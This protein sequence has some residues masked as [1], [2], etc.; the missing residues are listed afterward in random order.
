MN[1][2]SMQRHRQPSSVFRDLMAMDV[3][4]E[5]ARLAARQAT[6]TNAQLRDLQAR[7]LGPQGVFATFSRQVARQGRQAS[8][9]NDLIEVTGQKHVKQIEKALAFALGQ[10]R[11]RPACPNPF[12]GRSR[13]WLCCIVFDT[14]APCTVLE[15]YTAAEALR[16]H[17][18]DYF[19]LLIAT[20]RN[21]VERRLVFTGLLEHFDALLPIEQSIYPQDYRRAQQRH[22][23]R[24]QALYG[25]LVL[26][27][28][29]HV[30]LRKHSPEWLLENLSLFTCSGI[31]NAS[32]LTESETANALLPV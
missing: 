28:P 31:S 14:H 24:E 27:E 21:T 29:L 16:Q 7:L 26:N 23:D 32:A 5:F 6:C 12:A 9:L 17:D 13:A 4:R 30:L 10:H 11:R 2:L 18:G 19:S 8:A 25:D 1:V 20:T 15:R 22:L 3:D